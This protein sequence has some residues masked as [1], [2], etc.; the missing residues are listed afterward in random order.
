MNQRP[1]AAGTNKLWGGRFDQ[2]PNELFYQFQRSFPFDRRLLP[3]ELAVDRAWALAIEKVGILSSSETQQILAAIDAIA[4][5]AE[6]DPSWLDLSPAEDVH[7]FVEI[8]LVDLPW[9]DAGLEA[10]AHAIKMAAPG[11][12]YRD[13]H[14]LSACVTS[15][16]GKSADVT[17]WR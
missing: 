8:A 15:P 7:H 2:P 3:Y 5:R 10:D 11:P 14:H 13:D 16:A 4:E 17:F 6:S 12:A 9:S 1:T